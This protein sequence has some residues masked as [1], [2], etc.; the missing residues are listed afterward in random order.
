VTRIYLIVCSFRVFRFSKFTDNENK[1]KSFCSFRV[2]GLDILSM[3][4]LADKNSKNLLN[5][6]EIG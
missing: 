3:K 1:S 5:Y 2:F 4:P 6:A